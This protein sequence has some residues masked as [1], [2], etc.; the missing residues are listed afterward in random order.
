M[1]QTSI[2]E[3]VPDFEVLS[4][5]NKTIKMTDYPGALCRSLFLSERQYPGLYPGRPEFSRQF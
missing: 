1:N 2:G 4:T 3:T 5:G